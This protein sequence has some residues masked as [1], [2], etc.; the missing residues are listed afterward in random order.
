[1]P[2]SSVELFLESNILINATSGTEE[3]LSEPVKHLLISGDGSLLRILNMDELVEYAIETAILQKGAI[4]DEE[5]A[6]YRTMLI[7]T[8]KATLTKAVHCDLSF[9]WAS[10][11]QLW[12]NNQRTGKR[13]I[14]EAH[15]RTLTRVSASASSQRI[16][17]YPLSA[18]VCMCICVRCCPFLSYSRLRGHALRPADRRAE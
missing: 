6:S 16:H 17:S 5:K 2:A 1:V 15:A 9:I 12:T 13:T 4:S 10:W 18:S 7:H 14:E 8:Q 11:V 3:P